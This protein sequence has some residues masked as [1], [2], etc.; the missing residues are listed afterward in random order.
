M[1]VV[2]LVYWLF[3]VIANMYLNNT[4]IPVIYIKNKINPNQDPMLVATNIV[5]PMAIIIRMDPRVKILSVSGVIIIIVIIT[6]V[7]VTVNID[8]VR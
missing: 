5:L 3:G 4:S 2:D 8:A 1:E 7:S 6:T